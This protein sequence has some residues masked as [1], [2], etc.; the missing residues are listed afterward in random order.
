MSYLAKNGQQRYIETTLLYL[1]KAAGMRNKYEKDI[2]ATYTKKTFEHLIGDDT[3]IT[4][5]DLWREEGMERG[6]KHGMERGIEKGIQQEKMKT[7]REMLLLHLDP[8]LIAKITQLNIQE[9]LAESK[10]IEASAH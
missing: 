9:I 1:F 4:M 7:V 2:V 8:Q 5:A 10:K 3:M 6:I